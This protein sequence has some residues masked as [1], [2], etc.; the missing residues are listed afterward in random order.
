MA[1]VDSTSNDSSSELY[2]SC[3]IYSS[4]LDVEY[5][6]LFMFCSSFLSTRLHGRMSV[7]C[8]GMPLTSAVFSDINAVITPLF[9]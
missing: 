2:V 8:C 5:S 9:H 3:I 6:E 1:V 7:T 4:S